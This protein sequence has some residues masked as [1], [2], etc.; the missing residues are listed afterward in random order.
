[1]TAILEALSRSTTV[2]V[3]LFSITIPFLVA[4]IFFQIWSSSYI[5]DPSVPASAIAIAH[6]EQGVLKAALEHNQG[7]Q[8]KT[9]KQLGMHRSTLRQRIALYGLQRHGKA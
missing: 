6:A 8:I 4:F 2:K 9:A 3:Y 5:A 7:N 1:M